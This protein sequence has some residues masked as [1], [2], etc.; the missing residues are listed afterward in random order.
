MQPLAAYEL[1]RETKDNTEQLMGWQYRYM[2]DKIKF[3]K[4]SMVFATVGKNPWS[5]VT[6]ASRPIFNAA[7]PRTGIGWQKILPTDTNRMFVA[8]T[9]SRFAFPNPDTQLEGD[10]RSAAEF[11]SYYQYDQFTVDFQTNCQ[12]VS[13]MSTYGE[14]SL[15]GL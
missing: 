3:D 12:K 11:L 15:G 2:E 13:L 1:G 10:P 9:P 14:P 5:F 4:A 7:D 8:Q 6:V